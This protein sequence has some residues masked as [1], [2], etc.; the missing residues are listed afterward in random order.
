MVFDYETGSLPLNEE[1]S[2]LIFFVSHRHQ[3]HFNPAIFYPERWNGPVKYVLSRDVKKVVRK[4]D[5]VPEEKCCWLAAGEKFQLETEEIPLRIRTLRSTD[6]G[7]AFLVSVGEFQIYHAGDLNCWTWPED[8]KQHRNQMVAEYRREIQKLEGEK[9]RTAFC[10]LDPRLEE[11]YAEGFLW[12][13]EHV[14]ADCV[15]PMHMWE[16]YGTVDSLLASL[17]G[18]AVKQRIMRITEAGQQWDI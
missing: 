5:G 2:Q 14:D 8:T 10:P 18:K 7:V 3:D 1:I 13:L 4:M 11:N 12:F 6:C 9:I 16:D 15:W 17:E